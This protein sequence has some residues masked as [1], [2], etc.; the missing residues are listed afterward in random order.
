MSF[1]FDT[2][3]SP[4]N[5]PKYSPLLQPV[6]LAKAY[7]H[8]FL[9]L[10][11]HY[12]P[13]L[14]APTV[15]MSANAGR[16]LATLKSD[17]IIR[18]DNKF[19][20][21]AGHIDDCYFARLEGRIPN[22]GFDNRELFLIDSNVPKY[23]EGGT[24]IRANISFKD[25]KLAPLFFDSDLTAVLYN[26]YRRQ[27]FLRNYP[28]LQ[29]IAYK[30]DKASLEN[31]R[32]HVDHLHQVT[33]MFLICDLTERDT[34]MQY[35]IA[36]HKK[37]RIPGS[38]GTEDVEANFRIYDLIGK[39][40]TVFMFDAG[41]IHRAKYMQGTVRKMMTINFT[42][43]HDIV[44]MRYDKL[45]NWPHFNEFPTHIQRLLEKVSIHN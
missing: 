21:L 14:M 44:D 19:A 13:N 12:I 29:K 2:R 11:R 45:E 16:L 9:R 34:H 39:K 35:A 30:G 4:T 7:A 8:L 24:E 15:P 23:R 6:A 37:L 31:G 10:S 28:V 27:P 43:G 40:G 26:F 17:G 22:D 32:F 38:Y 20:E 3:I 42:T 1:V 41:G 36:S 5:L 18:I 33:I 25:P